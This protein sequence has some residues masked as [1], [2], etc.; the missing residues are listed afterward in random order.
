MS[1]NENYNESLIK[2]NLPIF[3]IFKEYKKI[4]RNNHKYKCVYNK[5]NKEYE[6]KNK[7]LSH[8]RTHLNIK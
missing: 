5:C 3:F 4:S 1:S 6:H 7:M 2:S 8:I